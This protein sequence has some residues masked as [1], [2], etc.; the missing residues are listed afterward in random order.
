MAIGNIV[1]VHGAFVDGSGWQGVYDHLV[2]DGYRVAVVQNPTLSLAGDAAATHQILDGL[3]GPAV[4]VGHSYGIAGA[5][6]AASGD[7]GQMATPIT[8]NNAITGTL[9]LPCVGQRRDAGGRGD[10]RW[11]HSTRPGRTSPGSGTIWLG[12]KDNFAVDREL[13][14]K[15]LEVNPLSAQMARENRRF[16][17]RA[18][19]YVAACGVRQ[20]ID[21]G[22]G[23]PTAVNTH[24]I[25]QEV[26]L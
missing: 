1:L 22:A 9:R 19:N 8:A 4:L 24:D 21:V 6:A 16:L 15:M 7:P 17:G 18:V 5:G 14:Q 12:G 13:A 2:A 11:S 10:G 23:L 25:A 26:D 3:S 20:F